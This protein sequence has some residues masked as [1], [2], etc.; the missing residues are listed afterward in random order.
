MFVRMFGMRSVHCG[1]GK[2]SFS[3]VSRDDES[4]GP[5][6]L[7]SK[8]WTSAVAKIDPLASDPA[9]PTRYVGCGF[10]FPISA[11]SVTVAAIMISD[12][13]RAARITCMT[14]EAIG[15]HHDTP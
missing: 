2:L 10:K 6:G 1:G 12:A 5:Y 15:R 9:D 13:R 8:L 3:L 7:W 4:R 11:E 14:V